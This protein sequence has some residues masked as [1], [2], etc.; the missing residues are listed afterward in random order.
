MTHRTMGIALGV[1]W[2]DTYWKNALSAA[3]DSVGV[4]LTEDQLVAMAT[5]LAAS[6]QRGGS[7][8]ISVPP[9]GLRIEFDE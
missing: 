5:F 9:L 1:D 7:G 2:L 6:E 8:F 3:A 4:V